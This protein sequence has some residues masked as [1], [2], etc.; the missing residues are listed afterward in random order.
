MIAYEAGDYLI[1][2]TPKKKK[3]LVKASVYDEYEGRGIIE[4]TVLADETEYLEFAQTNVITNLGQRPL[5]GKVHGVTVEPWIKTFETAIGDC[6]V[7]YRPTDPKVFTKMVT[8]GADKMMKL[9]T[10]WKVKDLAPVQLE[11]RLAKGKKAQGMHHA[12]KGRGEL[13]IIVCRPQDQYTMD[14]LLAHEFGHAIWTH[15]LNNKVKARW[16]KKYHTAVS[17]DEVDAK[18]CA[19][20]L[21]DMLEVDDSMP[22]DFA[23]QLEEEDAGPFNTILSWISSHHGLRTQD[24]DVLRSVGDDD[25]IS[26]VWPTHVTMSD[27]EVMITEYGMKNVEETFCECLA[28]Y[29]L[30]QLPDHL[31]TMVEKTLEAAAKGRAR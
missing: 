6:D 24:L 16:I 18:T 1:V 9:L 4:R 22:S 27:M 17:V 23:G 15:K 3:E 19:R 2:E 7:Y 30:G 8:A 31:E 14:Y 26:E 10:E 28:H 29:V 5:V 11:M 13:D 21:A 25:K 20:L 12:Y